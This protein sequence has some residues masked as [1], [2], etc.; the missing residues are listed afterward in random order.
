[1]TPSIGGQAFLSTATLAA[2][3]RSLKVGTTG[4]YCTIDADCVGPTTVC[5]LG[6]STTPGQCNGTADVQWPHTAPADDAYLAI[7]ISVCIILLFVLIGL[8]ISWFDS[9][10]SSY[11][12]LEL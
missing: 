1:M 12:R 3:S 4:N 10:Y 5:M 8:M 6:Q 2:C 7:I 11:N 9:R